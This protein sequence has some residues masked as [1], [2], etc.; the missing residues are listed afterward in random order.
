MGSHTI[1]VT[2]KWRNLFE[3]LCYSSLSL[4]FPT[5]WL[6]DS[7]RWSRSQLETLIFIIICHYPPRWKFRSCEIEEDLGLRPSLS[8]SFFLHPLPSHRN[9]DGSITLFHLFRQQPL[10]DLSIPLEV[11]TN[12]SGS[13]FKV[14]S[15]LYKVP[16]HPAWRPFPLSAKIFP[17]LR[18]NLSQG[19]SYNFPHHQLLLS[20]QGYPVQ[21]LGVA[22]QCAFQPLGRI[23]SMKHPITSKCP[24][25]ETTWQHFSNK[26]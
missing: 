12:W 1:T 13:W 8:S 10:P 4:P 15:P 23:S 7:T 19:K 3:N 11:Y 21:P 16:H 2:P 26:L 18:N 24:N 6:V 25:W 14:I 17:A 5:F 20:H 9:F 22:I